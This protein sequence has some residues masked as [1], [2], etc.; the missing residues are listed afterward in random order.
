M[1]TKEFCKQSRLTPRKVQWWCETGVLRCS[2][3][4]RGFR[5]FDEAELRVAALVAQLRRKGVAL[6]RIRQMRIRNPQ[7]DFL[8]ANGAAYWWCTR[9]ELLPELAKTRGACVVVSLKG[10]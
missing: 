3:R 4:E 1:S 2:Q 7:G 8:V 9:E 5:D 10:L 6:T